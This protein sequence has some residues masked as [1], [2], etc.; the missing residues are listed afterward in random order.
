MLRPLALLLALLAAGPALADGFAVH[1]LRTLDVDVGAFAG[2]AFEAEANEPGRLTIF[3]ADCEGIV[4]VDIILGR[5]DDETEERFRSGET[6]VGRM[7]AICR[8]RNPTCTLEGAQAGRAVGWVT[9]YEAA[10]RAESTTALFLDGD[11]LTIRSISPDPA[12][13]FA[14]GAAARETVAPLIVGSD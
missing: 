8:E 4:A 10:G 13:A 6:T 3:C 7:A 14:N 5:S 11:L 12:Q 1:D 9:H 2:G